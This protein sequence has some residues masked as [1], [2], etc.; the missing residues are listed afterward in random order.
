MVST[1]RRVYVRRRIAVGVAAT[2]VLAGAIYTPMTL[3]APVPTVAAETAEF[4]A[5]IT[6]PPAIAAAP[7]VPGFGVSGITA[8]GETGALATVDDGAQHPIAS[9]TKAITALVVLSVKP[10]DA[11]ADGEPIVLTDQDAGFYDWQI[12]L[13]GSAEPVT[14]GVT[15][16]QRDVLELMLLPSA[17]NYAQTLA[18]WAFGSEAAYVDAARA[19]LLEQGMSATT[20]VDA[21]GVDD[22]N[23][24]TVADLLMLGQLALSNPVLAPIVAMPAADVPDLGVV[25][26]SNRLLGTVGVDGIKTGTSP[27]AGACLLFSADVAV[28]SQTVTLVGVVLGGDTHAAVRDAVAALVT[29]VTAGYREIEVVAEDSPFAEFEQ[30]WGDSATAVTA[31]AVTMLVW[32]DTPVTI[33]ADVL[34]VSLAEAGTDV[35]TVTVT[36]G[37]RSASVPLRLDGTIDDPGAWWRLSHPGSL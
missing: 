8:I 21:S 1:S 4:A 14:P 24:S 5:A 17:N 9:I 18:T 10:M 28:G 20:I 37:P 31:S 25:E 3:L 22:A 27:L 34:S 35:G 29:S 19:W 13:G 7:V 32:S 2:A 16:S 11:T 33:T 15:M 36:S 6:P 30:V 26:N 23:A 12:S